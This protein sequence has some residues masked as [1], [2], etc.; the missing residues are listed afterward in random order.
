MT[1]RS[2]YSGRTFLEWEER[3]SFFHSFPKRENSGY[4]LGHTKKGKGHS[5]THTQLSVNVFHSYPTSSLIQ[6]P[7]AWYTILLTYP[8]AVVSLLAITH[9]WRRKTVCQYIGQSMH[10]LHTTVL[11]DLQCQKQRDKSILSLFFYLSVGR[12]P[13]SM[14]GQ[15][16]RTALMGFFGGGDR[17]AKD[18][19]KMGSKLAAAPSHD[20]Y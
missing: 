19:I 16:P 2:I 9:T 11:Q 8:N 12:K 18:R 6:C 10:N 3:S 13:N 14:L 17:A 1:D 15:T 5:Q 20:S 4:S 7:S